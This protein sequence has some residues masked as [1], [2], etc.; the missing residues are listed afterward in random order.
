MKSKLN[1]K[2]HPGHRTSR[3][4]TLV[5]MLLVLVILSTL[6]ALVYPN[7]AKHALRARRT[8]TKMQIKI[9]RTALAAFEMDNN[10]FPQGRNGLLGLV[11][12][13]RDARNWRGPYLDGPIPKDPWGHDYIYECPGKHNPEAYDI[14]SMAQDGVLGTEDDIASWQPENESQAAK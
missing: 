9:F 6:A 11:Q 2:Q 1:I 7:L 3:A 10:G 14:V 13:P 4:F 12:R 5:E 8:E